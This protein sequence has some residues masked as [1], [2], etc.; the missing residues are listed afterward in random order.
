LPQQQWLRSDVSESGT[1]DSRSA[2]DITARRDHP[3]G[4]R[5]DCESSSRPQK[6]SNRVF[7]FG[8][9]PMTFWNLRCSSA[10]VAH[11]RSFPFTWS[12]EY[13]QVLPTDLYATF[14][15]ACVPNR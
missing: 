7:H 2:G 5:S 15:S 3:V 9:L 4:P 13:D 8:K 14:P 12:M 1:G 6:I 11:E 10:E